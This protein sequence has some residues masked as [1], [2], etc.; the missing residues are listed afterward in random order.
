[1]SASRAP[2]TKAQMLG[3][4]T[5]ISVSQVPRMFM[6]A[7]VRCFSQ[8]IRL[9]EEAVT[10]NAEGEQTAARPPNYIPTSKSL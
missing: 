2:A 3:V 10:P 5:Q 7:A 6:P 4:A 9:A 8:T 1:M